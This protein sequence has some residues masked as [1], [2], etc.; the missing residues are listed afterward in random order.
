MHLH[1]FI[2]LN[3]YENTAFTFSMFA[4]NTTS[5]LQILADH[6]HGP[7]TVKK[8]VAHSSAV[9]GGWLPFLFPFQAAAIS[10]V[11]FWS[12]KRGISVRLNVTD[13]A[14]AASQTQRVVKKNTIV[15]VQT[16]VLVVC[17]HHYLV[18]RLALPNTAFMTSAWHGTKTVP[19]F[20]IL[21]L[22]TLLILHVLHSS[23]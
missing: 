3:S 9:G 15:A 21:T 17:C 4:V 11:L 7:Q 10:P 6:W 16:G 19:F 8:F 22:Q 14:K 13:C 18:W 1:G 5:L 20:L 2:Y 12:L 23:K